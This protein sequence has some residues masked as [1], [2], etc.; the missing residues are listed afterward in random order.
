MTPLIA[1]NTDGTNRRLSD[2]V[3]AFDDVAEQAA[4]AG[5]DGFGATTGT[6]LR[7]TLQ[8]SVYTHPMTMTREERSRHR[9]TDETGCN[10]HQMKDVPATIRSKH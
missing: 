5:P 2:S 7:G 8:L 4:G 6:P 3:F 10:S 9:I 1:A